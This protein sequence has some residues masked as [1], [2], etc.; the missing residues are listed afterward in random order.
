MI[1]LEKVNQM[2]KEHEN[3]DSSLVIYDLLTEAL[4]L[5]QAQ[6]EL[7]RVYFVT[8]ESSHNYTIPADKIEEWER[9][10][11]LDEDDPASWDVPDFASRCSDPTWYEVVLTGNG[12]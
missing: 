2:R 5:L 7:P 8:D 4:G 9:F 1:T 3:A 11:E 10:T 12:R 6:A